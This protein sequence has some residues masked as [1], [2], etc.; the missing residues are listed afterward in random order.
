MKLRKFHHY[1]LIA[2]A[3]I[4]LDQLT[5]WLA[6]EHLRYNGPTYLIGDWLKL[7]YTTNPGMAFGMALNV[8]WGK[9]ALTLFRLVAL[10][11]IIWYMKKFYIKKVHSGLL[12]CIALILAGAAGNL[13]DSTFY[14]LLDP[15]LLVK[16]PAPPF[17]L[18]HSQVIDFIYIDMGTHWGYM[19]WPIFNVA[20]SSIFVSV[21]IILIRQKAFFVGL[22][23]ESP[24]DETESV[25]DAET[26]KA[27]TPPTT[28]ES[29]SSNS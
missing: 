22:K 29:N 25:K 28:A 20:D 15:D 6:Y 3:V 23:K 11:V 8:W 13:I 4:I 1:L 19:L 14:G 5:K 16:S 7:Q 27:E 21:G 17:A 26:T 18:F 24:K 10:V 9:I 2:L 12:I